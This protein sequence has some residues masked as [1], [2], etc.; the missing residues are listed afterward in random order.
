MF[1]KRK[2]KARAA[3]IVDMVMNDAND[4]LETL[5]SKGYSVSISKHKTECLLL[6]INSNLSKEN[7]ALCG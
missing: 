5:K 7:H 6:G 1:G 2:M 3:K 4:L